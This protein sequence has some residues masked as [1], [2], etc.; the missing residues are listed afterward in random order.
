MRSTSALPLAQAGR[1]TTS[2]NTAERSGVRSLDPASPTSAQGGG[3][4]LAAAVV[5]GRAETLLA[6]EK[7]AASSP[8]S[9]RMTSWVASLWDSL[10]S[11]WT[12]AERIAAPG[13][14]ARPVKR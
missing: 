1:F 9:A 14:M 8:A 7:A 4:Q 13:G 10:A 2:W 11:N 12:Y 6:N 5:R 3:A